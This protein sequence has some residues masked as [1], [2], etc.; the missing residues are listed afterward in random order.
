MKYIVTDKIG[1]K[2]TL[3]ISEK[4]KIIEPNTY[5]ERFP[6]ENELVFCYKKGNFQDC[7][8]FVDKQDIAIKEC[9]EIKEIS[10]ERT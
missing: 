8:A 3:D 7:K 10:G 4:L 5:E 9:L 2:M 6:F 1:H